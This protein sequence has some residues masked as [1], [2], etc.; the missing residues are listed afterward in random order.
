MLSL[1]AKRDVKLIWYMIEDSRGGKSRF[2]L[3]TPRKFRVQFRDSNRELRS[4]KITGGLLLP[5][6]TVF[7]FGLK[8]SRQDH[9]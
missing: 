4:G 9:L 3:Q 6:L 2:G 7:A 1:K 5:P 8:E